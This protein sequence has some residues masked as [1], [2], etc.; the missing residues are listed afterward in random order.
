MRMRTAALLFLSLLQLF[1]TAGVYAD[2]ALAYLEPYDAL[3][4]KHVRTEKTKDLS[5]NLVSYSHWKE[6]PLHTTAMKL[7]GSAKPDA[8]SHKEKLVFWINAYNLLTIDLIISKNEKESIRNL[9]S[10][11]RTPWSIY[12]WTIGDKKYTL[13]AIEH[14]ILR[15]MEEP[16][17]HMAIVCA[18]ISCPDL[19]GEA[20]TVK[21]LERQLSEQTRHFLN[22]PKKGFKEEKDQLRVSMIFKWFAKDFGKKKGVLAFIKKYH[23]IHNQK[24]NSLTYLDYNWNLNGSW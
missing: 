19:R 14:K 17:I 3:L 11:F 12:K 16:R 4:H 2:D 22:D 23:E 5:L 21:D 18:S 10:W 20:F 8:L 6:D 9:G 15:K 24:I 7:L 1:I 13:D